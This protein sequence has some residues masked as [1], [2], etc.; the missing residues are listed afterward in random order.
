VSDGLLIIP[1]GIS[2]LER[3]FA[4][5]RDPEI[6]LWQH[7]D[8]R[9]LELNGAGRGEVALETSENLKADH[10]LQASFH[11]ICTPS[12]LSAQVPKRQVSPTAAMWSGAGLHG[13]LD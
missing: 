8:V 4:L 2:A 1:P 5:D 7:A 13:R 12:R 9:S 6:S 11:T 10:T 3:S